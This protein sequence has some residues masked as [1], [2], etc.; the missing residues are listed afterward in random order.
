[1]PDLTVSLMWHPRMEAD[2]A[3][4][5]LRECLF[6]ICGAAEDAQ[7]APAGSRPPAMAT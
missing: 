7:G 1:M 5:W 6:D 4:R 3:H 2:P